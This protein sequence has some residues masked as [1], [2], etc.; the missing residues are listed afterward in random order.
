[1]KMKSLRKLLLCSLTSSLALGASLLTAAEPAPQP[2]PVPPPA[3]PTPTTAAQPAS[4][5]LTGKVVAMDKVKKAITVEI[6]GRVFVFKISRQITV[7]VNGEE[8][9]L[10]ALA[11]GQTISLIA[12]RN[13]AGNFEIV[14]LDILPQTDK[15]AVAGAPSSTGKSAAKRSNPTLPSQVYTLPTPFRTEPNPANIAGNVISPN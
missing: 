3:R 13:V 5:A 2:A 11:P 7:R 14:G 12:R 6:K 15:I 1:M 8:V 10:T 9:P 4:S